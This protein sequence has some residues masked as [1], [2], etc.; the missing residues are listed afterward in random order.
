MAIYQFYAE[1]KIP[2][3]LDQVWDFISSP[4]NLKEITPD[5]MGFDI[6]TEHLAEKMY[7]GMIITYKVIPLMGI[8]MNWVDTAAS[9]LTRCRRRASIAAFA[10]KRR[11]S[12]VGTPSRVGVT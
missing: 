3:G 2:A 1:Q 7:P 6:T 12:T 8:R 4:E 10:S 5:Y 9:T 11:S